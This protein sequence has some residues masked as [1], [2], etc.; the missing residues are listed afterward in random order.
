[1]PIATPYFKFSHFKA[2]LIHSDVYN[3]KVDKELSLNY[4][5]IRAGVFW[6]RFGL[7]IASA[8]VRSVFERTL[9]K[10]A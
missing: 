5:V 4:H 7:P 8:V 1:M 6:A 9:A 10:K 2:V 3:K